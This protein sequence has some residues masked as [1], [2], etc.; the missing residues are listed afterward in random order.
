M[1]VPAQPLPCQVALTAV[2]SVG[3]VVVG[4]VVVEVVAA[5]V[6]AVVETHPS[7]QAFHATDLTNSSSAVG[8]QSQ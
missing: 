2:A 8:H 4:L 7:V 5:V 1:V 3:Q 6:V